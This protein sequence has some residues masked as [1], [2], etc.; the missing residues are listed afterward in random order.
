M[1][2]SI[3]PPP[4]KR[5][6][7]VQ[8]RSVGSPE[9]NVDRDSSASHLRIYSWNVNGLS[10]FLQPSVTC[11]FASK[12]SNTSQ[13]TEVGTPSLRDV[14]RRYDWPGML[15]LHEVKI[16]PDDRAS[17]RAIGKAV[18]RATSEPIEEPAY[19]ALFVCQRTSTTQGASDERC[20]GFAASY[21]KISSPS[22]R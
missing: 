6:R 8:S 1:P 3:S 19:R 11:F 2:T 10:P 20:T 14:L 18:S 5:R 21:V 22:S 13:S 4:L 12:G 16:K 17:Q 15:L 7:F 9:H